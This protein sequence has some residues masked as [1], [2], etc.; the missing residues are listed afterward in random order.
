MSESDTAH[1]TTTTTDADADARS[2]VLVANAHQNQWMVEA[3][4]DRLDDL[5]TDDFV[6]IHITGY[7]QSKTDW[8]TEIAQGSMSYHTVREQSITVTVEGSTAVLVARNLVTATIWGTK[9]V[10]PLQMT[11]RFVRDQGGWRPAHSRANTF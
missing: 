8:L 10:W 9:A 5:L 11:T 4:V 3:D 7:P 6:L 1:G 2:A